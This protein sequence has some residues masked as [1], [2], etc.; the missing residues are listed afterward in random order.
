MYIAILKHKIIKK[1]YFMCSL[2]PYKRSSIT[3]VIP[4]FQFSKGSWRR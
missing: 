2:N 1:N 3:K 4:T